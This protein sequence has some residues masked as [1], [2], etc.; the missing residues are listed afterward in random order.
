MLEIFPKICLLF[1]KLTGAILKLGM[2]V[3]YLYHILCSNVILNT[4][5]EESNAIEKVANTLLAPAHYLLEGKVIYFDEEVSLYRTRQRFNYEKNKRYSSPL[6]ITLLPASLIMGGSLKLLSLSLPEVRGRHLAYKEQIGKVIVH[7]NKELFASQGI[8]INDF[9]QGDPLPP[10]EHVRRPGDENHLAADKAVFRE[11]CELLSRHE[12]PFWLDC[13]TLLGAYRYGGVIP[14]DND[15]DIAVLEAD[16]DN[17]WN[18]LKKL[19]P[20]KAIAQ[21]WSNRGRPRTYIRVYVKESQNHID[22]YHNRVDPETRT[23]TNILSNENSNFMA[24][25]W[26]EQE[27]R[28]LKPLKYEQIFPLKQATFDGISVPVP[29]ETIAYLELKYSGDISPACIYD[30][31]TGEFE[32]VLNHPYWNDSLADE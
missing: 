28:Y 15:L 10:P 26:K 24:N 4:S 6:A 11:M 9:K 3:V 16:F 32:K 31:T 14:W 18:A 19:D 2:I 12:I 25:S 8:E 27:R 30:E 7:S 1:P 20:T 13:G 5:F 17:I 23:I 22:I 21:D 29:C